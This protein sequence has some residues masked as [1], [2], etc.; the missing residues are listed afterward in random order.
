[1]PQF[2]VVRDKA[3]KALCARSAADL[4]SMPYS[5]TEER[6]FVMAWEELELEA[7]RAINGEKPIAEVFDGLAKTA[8]AELKM[9]LE[10]RGYSVALVKSIVGS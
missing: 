2:R 4:K 10:K 8:T 6:E 1:M 3:G 7:A 9:E 5:A